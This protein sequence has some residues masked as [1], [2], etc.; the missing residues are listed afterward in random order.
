[1]FSSSFLKSVRYNFIRSNCNPMPAPPSITSRGVQYYLPGFCPGRAKVTTTISTTTTTTVTEA[2]CTRS[3]NGPPWAEYKTLCHWKRML[4]ATWNFRNKQQTW[5]A[6][7]R[8][9]NA[10]P[11]SREFRE[12]LRLIY[13]PEVDEFG[14]R[15]K[16]GP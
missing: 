14:N 3:A 13:P 15:R 12:R 6:M 8:E 9:L 10:F 16:H 4:Q 11:A 1:M 2:P 5:S 7:G